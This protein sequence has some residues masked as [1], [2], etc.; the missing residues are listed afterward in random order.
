[1]RTSENSE[2][3]QFCTVLH[4]FEQKRRERGL[5]TSRED[6]PASQKNN[7]STFPFSEPDA[8][9]SPFLNYRALPR[10]RAQGVDSSVP[11]LLSRCVSRGV[12]LGVI[13]VQK[14]SKPHYKPGGGRDCRSPP[15]L[16]LRTG[17]TLSARNASARG[18][19]AGR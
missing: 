7:P 18:N 12:K 14:V 15:V 2:N 9:L 11:G 16:L 1:L 13:S 8:R 5:K 10:P 19:T 17:F 3:C 6:L 4:R